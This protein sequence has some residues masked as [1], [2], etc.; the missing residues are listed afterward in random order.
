MDG[1]SFAKLYGALG[2][3]GNFTDDEIDY[4][5]KLLEGKR[6]CENF[7]QFEVPKNFS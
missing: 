4:L 3:K 7:S 1:L 5:F 2:I 6:L